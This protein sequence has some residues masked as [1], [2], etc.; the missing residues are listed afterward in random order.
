MAYG[1]AVRTKNA[2]M[3]NIAERLESALVAYGS[4]E[5]NAAIN[6]TSATMVDY[7]SSS[8]SVTVNSGE[9]V[10]LTATVLLSHGTSGVI[11][12]IGISQ[13]GTDITPS[14][15]FYSPRANTG[16]VDGQAVFHAIRTPSAGSHTY[17]IRWK[18]ASGT[19]YSN[20]SKLI[21]KVFQNS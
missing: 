12:D 2:T 18:T 1:D 7:T 16:G 10:E 5:L 11:S 9:F 15:P 6:T 8:V 20:G 17:K 3:E 4:Q 19:A 14:T 13:D 21:V